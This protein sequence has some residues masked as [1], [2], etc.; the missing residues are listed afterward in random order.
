METSAAFISFTIFL[1]H[2]HPR[3]KCTPSVFCTKTIFKSWRRRRSIGERR[4]D[5]GGLRSGGGWT[6]RY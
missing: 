5:R 3:P 1:D 6:W 2:L 4:L